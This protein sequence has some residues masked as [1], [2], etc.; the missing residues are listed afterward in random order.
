MAIALGCSSSSERVSISCTSWALIAADSS[1][2]SFSLMGG[3]MPFPGRDWL[4]VSD[5]ALG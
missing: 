1:A 2:L 3:L 5:A 4:A